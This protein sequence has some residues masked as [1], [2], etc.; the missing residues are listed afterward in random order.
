MTGEQRER[1]RKVVR[2]AAKHVE[3]LM[4]KDWLDTDYRGEWEARAHELLSRVADKAAQLGM[5]EEQVDNELVIYLAHLACE[6]ALRKA[7][8][9]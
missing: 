4:V 5:G 6:A 7:A 2:M 8:A 1:A 9:H 3:T